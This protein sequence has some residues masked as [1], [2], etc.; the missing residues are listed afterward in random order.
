M[1]YLNFGHSLKIRE[2]L[3]N[4]TKYLFK[5]IPWQKLCSNSLRTL[6]LIDFS[7][8][9]CFPSERIKN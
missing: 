3:E 5:Y 2:N 6:I 7:K 4:W 1:K 9:T 8:H